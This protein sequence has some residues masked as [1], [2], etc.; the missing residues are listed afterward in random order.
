MIDLFDPIVKHIAHESMMSEYTAVD[1]TSMRV[2][3][4]EHPLGIR[5]TALWLIEG[6][7]KYA[8]FAYAPSG[9]AEHLEKLL[10][11]YKLASVMC[12]GSYTNNCVERAGGSR[13]GCNS[14]ARR[15]L[16]DALRRGDDRALAGLEIFAS[17]FHVDAESRKA[18]ES[19]ADRHI[20]RQQQSS[21]LIDRLRAWVDARLLDV[22]PKT[23][24]GD[25]IRYIHRQW[26][27]LT[28]FL[29][30]PLMELTNNEVERDLRRW[31]L[32]RRT[33]LFC[34]HEVSARRA[35]DALTIITTCRKHGIDPR[36]YIRDTLAKL[37]DGEKNLTSLLPETYAAAMR[38]PIVAMA[39]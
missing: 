24:L 39:A 4:A 13:G 12:D 34:G 14:H 5:T 33:W 29:R 8:Y 26:K 16:V 32:D 3:D 22:E 2:L 27:R 11:G 28:L 23:P 36:R 21:P 10:K 15:G 38:V 31:V 35:A 18:G 37:L 19:L 30:D 9:H 6:D 17:I 20:R 1:A 25:A 7:H